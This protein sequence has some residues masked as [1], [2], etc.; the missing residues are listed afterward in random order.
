[1]LTPAVR[2]GPVDAEKLMLTKCYVSILIEVR[3]DIDA[4]NQESL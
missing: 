1:V 2:M 4:T 3:R